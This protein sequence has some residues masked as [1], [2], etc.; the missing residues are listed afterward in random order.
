MSINWHDLLNAIALVMIIEGVLPFVSPGTLKKSYQTL[1]DLPE[2]TLRTIGLV[3]ILV[4]LFV[5]FIH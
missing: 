3:S 5:L 1:L 4:G 2:S